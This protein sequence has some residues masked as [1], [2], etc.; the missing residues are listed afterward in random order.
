MQELAREGVVSGGSGR[1][2]FVTTAMDKAV[3]AIAVVWSVPDE[4]IGTGEG[5]FFM[6]LMGGIRKACA[7]M[8]ITAHFRSAQ[9]SAYANILSETRAQGLL[10]VRPDYNDVHWLERLAAEG[11]P[12]VAVPGI[13]KAQHVPAISA[14]NFG[15]MDQAVDHLVA[16]GHRDI[17]VVS[18]TTMPD[19][20]ERL[21]G[22]LSAMARQNL[23]VNP[24][25]I[26]VRN[27]LWAEG[28]V[29]AVREGMQES[30]QLPTAIIAADLLMGLAV[31]RRL[32]ELGKS[33]PADVSLVNFDD[34]PAA[35]H[36]TPALTVIK[37]HTA[38]LGA[39]GVQRLIEMIRGDENVPLIERLPTELIVRE[40]TARPR[41]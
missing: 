9:L 6:Q 22:F 12:V 28:Y 32:K 3:K 35:A 34:T 1:R 21:Q 23:V 15:G 33:V 13:L 7:E 2:T 17:G 27:E 38:T 14:D 16:L 10:V 5:D 24:Q 25:W 18:L 11:I 41:H 4:Q 39:R 36:M 37:Q 26:L 19:H 30:M 20:F 8:G 31:Q 40:S 29:R